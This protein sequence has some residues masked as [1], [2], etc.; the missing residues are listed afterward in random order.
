MEGT[1]GPEIMPLIVTL[2][3]LPLSHN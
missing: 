3:V 1:I 2:V